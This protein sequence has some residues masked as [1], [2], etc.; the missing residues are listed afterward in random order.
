M[1]PRTT[2]LLLGLGP[3]LLTC[4]A[5]A[6][7]VSQRAQV[8]SEMHVQA[9]QPVL[10]A[11]RKA[12]LQS[13][14]NLGRSAIAHLVR[15]GM[16]DARA[17][18][19]ALVILRRLEFG[20]DGYFF[21]Y[22]FNGRNLLHPRQPELEGQRLMTKQDSRGRF[23]IQTL[24]AQ[25]RAGGGY[26][27]YEWQRPSSGQ[28]EDKL[29]YVEPIAGWEW[30]LGTGAYF[31]ESAEARVRID[32]ATEQA[33]VDT[34]G[35][36]AVV[37]LLGAMAV[38][39]GAL[40]L[41]FNEQRKADAQ[42]R[43]MAAQ[44]VRGQE[45]ERARVARE[46]HDGVQQSLVSVKFLFESV[47]ARARQAQVDPELSH[48][49]DAGVVRLREVLGEVRGIAHDLRPTL[50]DD[51]G[52][53]QALAHLAREWSER[54]GVPVVLELGDAGPLPEALTTA[55]FRFVQEALGNVAQHAEA[56]SVTLQLTRTSAGLRLRVQDDGRGFDVDQ[57][58]QSP[59]HGLGLTH[60]RERVESL[61]GRYTLQSSA[62]GTLL[63]A[64]FAPR[65]LQT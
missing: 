54:N 39:A 64:D 16:P 59:R 21:V 5:L 4:L 56:S 58:S 23:P 12:E 32:R 62:T 55:L 52:L 49:L 30:M 35:R 65:A 29:G 34:L 11:A 31:D 44:L 51:L 17:Q 36:V 53:T 41:N 22:D 43:A 27:T 47:L 25:A 63:G 40:V 38:A 57:F 8:L 60:L 46:L 48:Q 24:L 28:V 42:L 37:A 15:D 19:E 6:W 50:L 18:A 9:V 10:L 2:W 7:V 61:G 26:V 13:K 14:V 33:V 1:Q 3:L 20:H 45:D